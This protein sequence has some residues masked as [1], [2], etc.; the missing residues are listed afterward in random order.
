MAA[1]GEKR[2]RLAQALKKTKLKDAKTYWSYLEQ[3]GNK[4]LRDI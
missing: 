2:V 3:E 4:C 1:Q